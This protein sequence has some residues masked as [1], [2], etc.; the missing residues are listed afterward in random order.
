MPTDKAQ[1]YAIYL[2][3]GGVCL[4]VFLMAVFPHHSAIPLCIACCTF[5]VFILYMTLIG[6]LRGWIRIFVGTRLRVYRRTHDP[7]MYWV[8]LIA[9]FL[10]GVIA[11]SIG[12]Y[13]LLH[14]HEL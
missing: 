11:C 4:P 7:V 1:R 14:P 10:M 8:N 13:F 9:S 6:I 2:V 5:G 3:L 12:V